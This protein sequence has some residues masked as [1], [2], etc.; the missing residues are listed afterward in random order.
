MFK[1]LAE[2]SICFGGKEKEEIISIKFSIFFVLLALFPYQKQTLPCPHFSLCPTLLSQSN[3]DLGIIILLNVT[4][5]H[6]KGS[7]GII[8]L[9]VKCPNNVFGS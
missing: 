6:L 7:V 1:D 8:S 9:Y 3:V 5:H 4:E 2:D